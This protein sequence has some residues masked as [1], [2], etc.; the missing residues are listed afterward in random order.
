MDAVTIHSEHPFM[1]AEP[2]RSPV[3]RLRGRLASPVTLWTAGGPGPDT[4]RAGLTVSS[5]LIADG[6]PGHIVGVIDPLSDLWDSVRAGGAAVVTILDWRQR[7]LADMFGYVAPAPG[8]PFAAAQWRQSAFGPVL[9]ADPAVDWA[10]CRLA[11]EPARELGWGLLV[12]LTIVEVHLA[13]DARQAG[14]AQTA[15]SAAGQD[16]AD[17]TPLAPLVHRRGR[18]LRTIG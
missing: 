18:Y 3:R 12:T 9:A 11:E 13:V 5:V 6:E 10:G 4:P 16:S 8:G 1:P 2:D 7:Q 15:N 14:A 17:A